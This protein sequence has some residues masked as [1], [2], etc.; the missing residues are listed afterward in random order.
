MLALAGV[1][2]Y[3][4]LNSDESPEEE[5]T[6]QSQK[7]EIEFP[8]TT[9]TTVTQASNLPDANNSFNFALLNQIRETIPDENIFI[10]PL[11]FEMALLMTHNGAAGETAEEMAATLG[12]SKLSKDSILEESASLMALLNRS[13]F[14]VP[15]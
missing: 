13:T 5:N 10:S 6:P 3:I 2:A 12:I 8:Q 4:Y 1:S 11:S 7:P 15:A 14:R 9:T